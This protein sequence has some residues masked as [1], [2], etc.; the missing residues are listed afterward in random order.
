MLADNAK[1]K[2][3]DALKAGVL[4]AMPFMTGPSEVTLGMVRSGHISMVSASYQVDLN[5]PLDDKSRQNSN[6]K[7]T[8]AILYYVSKQVYVVIISELLY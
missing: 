4:S 5:I 1:S 6:E 3:S 8:T 2:L 7:S